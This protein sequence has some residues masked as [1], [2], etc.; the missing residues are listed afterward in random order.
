MGYRYHIFSITAASALFALLSGITQLA[1]AVLEQLCVSLSFSFNTSLPVGT[2][3][4]LRPVSKWQ[5]TLCCMLRDDVR[6]RPARR[7]FAMYLFWHLVWAAHVLAMTPLNAK[8]ELL[9]L[10][11][12][13]AL[14]VELS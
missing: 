3:E 8:T 1:N 10:S 12:V 4:A 7:G 13:R 5:H 14:R 2:Q 6:I 11:A 9:Y